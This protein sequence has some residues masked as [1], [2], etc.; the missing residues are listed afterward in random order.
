MAM[1]FSRLKKI[2]ADAQA[3]WDE[4]AL[5]SQTE[6][7][8]LQKFAHFSLMVWRSFVRNRCPV[9]ASARAYATLL[10]LIPML[11]LVMSITSSFLKKEGEDRMDQFI[12]KLVA[13]ITPR[14]ML[15]KDV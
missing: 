4:T 1:R 13:N 11:A 3:L 6:L 15:T 14:A 5:Q 7:S 10:A 9:R 12:A 8:K 2:R